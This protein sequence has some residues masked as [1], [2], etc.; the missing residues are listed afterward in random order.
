MAFVTQG[1]F[2]KKTSL[3]QE[4]TILNHLQNGFITATKQSSLLSFTQE[5]E[6]NLNY[7]RCYNV[8]LIIQS[9]KLLKKEKYKKKKR[10]GGEEF[11]AAEQLIE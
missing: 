2:R 7:F 6:Q 8:M 11:G 5:Q 10:G 4:N 3:E 9:F 1:I